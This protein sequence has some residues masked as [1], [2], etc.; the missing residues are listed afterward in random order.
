MTLNLYYMY[1]EGS[2]SSNEMEPKSY[3]KQLANTNNIR[4]EIILELV[5]ETRQ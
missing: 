3:L 4:K 1:M 5:G 2:G